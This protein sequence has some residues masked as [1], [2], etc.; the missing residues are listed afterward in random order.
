MSQEPS[1]LTLR[2]VSHIRKRLLLYKQATDAEPEMIAEYMQRARTVYANE[3]ATLKPYEQLA[4]AFTYAIM[5]MCREMSYRIRGEPLHKGLLMLPYKIGKCRPVYYSSDWSESIADRKRFRCESNCCIWCWIRTQSK[6]LSSL[7]SRGLMAHRTFWDWSHKPT[8]K[9]YKNVEA[10]LKRRGYKVLMRITRPQIMRN[11]YTVF[12]VTN[13]IQANQEFK[14][15][16]MPNTFMLL[17]LIYPYQWRLAKSSGATLLEF[18]EETKYLVK[19]KTCK[20]TTVGPV[21]DET[22]LYLRATSDHENIFQEIKDAQESN[23]CE[24]KLIK[25]PDLFKETS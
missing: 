18:V 19:F 16:Y 1:R 6:M 10:R 13:A 9:D 24:V 14:I 22:D 12:W 2:K 17:Q 4:G 25:H 15:A 8:W 21:D 23:N 3:L 11:G 20:D 7:P 5:D